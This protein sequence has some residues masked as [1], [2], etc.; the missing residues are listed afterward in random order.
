[1]FSFWDKRIPTFLGLLV[2][3]ISLVGLTY[4][5]TKPQLFEIGAGQPIQ[6]EDIRVSNQGV[7]SLS[8]SFRTSKEAAVQ[9]R[10]GQTTATAQTLFDD[11][12]EI[13]G[14][15]QA[16]R[17]HHVTI[18]NLTGGTQYE[19]TVLASGKTFD[20][21][22]KP[23]LAKT[24]NTATDVSSF[25]E[26]PIRGKV[27]L[28]NGADAKDALVYAKIEGAS[29][30]STVSK[31]DGS[32]LIPLVG[33]YTEDLTGL[34]IMHGGETVHIEVFG[35]DGSTALVKA[36][37]NRL[38]EPLV[39]TLGKN[40]D[41]ATTSSGLTDDDQEESPDSSGFSETEIS[42]TTEKG[43]EQ[44]ILTPKEGVFLL[45]SKP[46]IR[47]RGSPS[48]KIEVTVESDPQTSQLTVNE[49]GEWSYQPDNA[50][51]PGKH[52]V[53]VRFFDGDKITKVITQEFEVLASG[54]QV[55][56]S[57]TSSPSPTEFFFP[58]PSPFLT[59]A[60][61]AQAMPNT[62]TIFPSLSIIGGGVIL[63]VGGLFALYFAL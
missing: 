5:T 9:L 50:L 33:V 45:D 55:V 52:T 39:I 54:S 7:T 8:V 38:G 60:P 37:F 10:F 16:Y 49:N 23:F 48:Q 53:S 62:A 32:F 14:Q 28:S 21:Q 40:V 27:F 2:L 15:M 43:E 17:T 24:P 61:T 19:F 63:A 35:N 30:I 29:Y 22:G 26:Q 59:A 11:R 31:K 4:A 18:K 13:G 57:A 25:D 6:L 36:P 42:Q 1:M 51:P 47:G 46:L 56:E 34:Y 20:N 12:D 58:S 41:L 3:G 44:V